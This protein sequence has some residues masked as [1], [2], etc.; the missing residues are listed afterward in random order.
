MTRKDKKRIYLRVAASIMRDAD[1]TVDGHILVFEDRT[2]L[3]LMEE[4]LERERSGWQR[5]VDSRLRLLMIRNPLASI[6][7]SVQVLRADLELESEDDELLGIVEREANR[8][9]H[10]VSDFL[11][12]TREES[13]QLSQE[14]SES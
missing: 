8:L 6:T 9:G 2:R 3:L 7:G 10:L 11:H 12:L 5:S 14:S 4:Q 13:P 1:G